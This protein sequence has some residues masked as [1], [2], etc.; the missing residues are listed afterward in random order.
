MFYDL[1]GSTWT[2][3]FKLSLKTFI[4]KLPINEIEDAIEISCAKFHD[5]EEATKYFC[6]ICWNKIKGD[7]NG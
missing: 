5:P 7:H 3:K 1:S 2:T 4:D 6:G